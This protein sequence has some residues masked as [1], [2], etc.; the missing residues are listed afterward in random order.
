M[1]NNLQLIIMNKFYS[2]TIIFV[3]VL[4]FRVIIINTYQVNKIFPDATGYHTL[5]VNLAKGNGLTLQQE[6]PYE[7]SYFRE[8]VYPVFLGLCFHAYNFIGEKCNYI[9]DYDTVTYSYN[10]TAHPEIVFTKYVQAVI[11]SLS[12]VI[13]YLILLLV[14]KSSVA[15]VIAL[16][17]GF[18]FPVAIHSTFL[19]RETLQ[20]F[21]TLCM[22]FSF[23][24]YL[25]KKKGIWLLAFSGFWALSNLTLQI[26]VVIPFFVFFIVW[27]FNRSILKTFSVI[28]L[29]TIVMFVFISPWIMNVYKFYPDI[30]ILKTFGCSLTY[31]MVSQQNA[32]ATLE[33][34]NK[35]TK[36]TA[37]SLMEWGVSSHEQFRKSFDGTYKHFTD[38]VNKLNLKAISFKD[39]CKTGASNFISSW[40]FSDKGSGT[41]LREFYKS[42][43]LLPSV[44]I[45]LFAFIGL[46]VYFKKIVPILLTFICFISLFY[47]IGNE[48]RR[49]LPAQPFIFLFGCLGMYYSYIRFVLKKND[50]Y[51]ILI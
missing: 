20:L 32:V 29:S 25:L 43:T 50:Y 21:I 13:F 15:A 33:R 41:I 17:F 30:R 45:G 27:Y 38:S 18:Y 47:I 6:K 1:N 16:L 51:S 19:L 4:I 9:T 28:I 46:L 7:K 26:T 37:R 23:S 34:N 12:V 42:L 11:D 49:M 48:S 14:I 3:L 22:T 39:R 40:F 2:A 8:P 36:E 24:Q 10:S 44:I 5:G 31:E 35:I